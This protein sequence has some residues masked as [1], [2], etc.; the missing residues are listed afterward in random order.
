MFTDVLGLVGEFRQQGLILIVNISILKISVNFKWA[1]EKAVDL[2]YKKVWKNEEPGGFLT[3][4]Q[5]N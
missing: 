5:I 1:S 4:L 3:L 2:F